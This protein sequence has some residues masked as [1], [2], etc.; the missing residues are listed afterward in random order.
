MASATWY[1]FRDASRQ[2]RRFQS[3]GWLRDEDGKL[4]VLSEAKPSASSAGHRVAT[5]LVATAASGSCCCRSDGDG[6]SASGR[7][8]RCVDTCSP[9][10]RFTAS[11]P[12]PNRR[13][14]RNNERFGRSDSMTRVSCVVPDSA[15]ESGAT[16]SSSV[17]CEADNRMAEG[18]S[19]PSTAALGVS[20][21]LLAGVHRQRL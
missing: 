6:V 19:A 18:P 20:E 3:G 13:M 1:G 7:R 14:R 15:T 10:L 21:F 17:F 9:T 8:P 2:R 11:R 12:A 4:I 5:G 16:S